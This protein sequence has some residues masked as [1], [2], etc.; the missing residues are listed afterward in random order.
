M[1]SSNSDFSKVFYD[2][3]EY[4]VATC[5]SNKLSEKV[6][7]LVQVGTFINASL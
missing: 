5:Q 1:L 2:C 6:D 3:K 4:I 7:D